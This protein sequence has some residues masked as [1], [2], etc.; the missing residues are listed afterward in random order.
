MGLSQLESN[1]GSR[2][3]APSKSLPAPDRARVRQ[4]WQRRPHPFVLLVFGM[5]LL[6]LEF[7]VQSLALE[8]LL[9]L[10]ALLL[11][12]VN[13]PRRQ[14]EILTR[15]L[16]PMPWILL[17]TAFTALLTPEPAAAFWQGPRIPLLGTV[18][19]SWL[20]LTTALTQGLRLWAT[21]ITV[22]ALG[23]MVRVDDI[24]AWLG[25]RFARTS[26]TLAMVLSFI[27][28]LQAERQRLL[29]LNLVRGVTLASGPLKTRVKKAAFVYLALLQNALERS[30]MLAE[31]MHV[32]GYGSARRTRYRPQV[33]RNRDWLLMTFALLLLLAAGWLL[34]LPL[35][36][37]PANPGWTAVCPD[38]AVLAEVAFS[39]WLGGMFHGAH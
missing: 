33:W 13:R 29:E 8:G 15:L 12:G 1:Y 19:L 14:R 39:V 11:A 32:R 6:G 22:M 16:W 30:W 20:G 21:L 2:V 26:L 23:A 18:S 10:N 31:S 5:G 3:N 24:T 38:I 25:A 34:V 17:Y 37:A 4:P 9:W 36:F 28:N 35:F 27:P 7:G